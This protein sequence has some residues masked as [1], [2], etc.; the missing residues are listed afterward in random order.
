MN[1]CLIVALVSA[2]LAPS[3]QSP[4]SDS[5]GFIRDWL[6][7][8]PIP[9]AEDSGATEIEN[10]FLKGEGAIKPKGGDKVTVNGKSLTWTSHSAPAFYID[11]LKAFGAERG[12][13]A[14]AYAVT[15]VIAD[16]PMQVTLA[17]G[18]NDQAKAWVN[19]HPVIKFTETRT[20]EKD[21]DTADVALTKGQ[22]VLVLKVINEK[23]NW[24]GCAR[25]TKGGAPVKNLHISLTPE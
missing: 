4:G 17:I 3:P 10:D 21:T 6:V 11:F 2:M 1:T 9:V 14:A 20:L 19:G 5:D 16:E 23:N 18:S 25:F 12:E 22:N 24:Q 7:L 8:A 13:D 15:Y